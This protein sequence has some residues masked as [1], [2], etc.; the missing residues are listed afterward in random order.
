MTEDIDGVL[1][2]NTG[3]H[4]N[5]RRAR[6][7]D[8][9]ALAEFFTHVTPEDLRFRFLSGMKEVSHARLLEMTRADDRRTDNFL[10]FSTGETLV[11]VAML[12]SDDALRHG[13]VAISIRAD[14][15]H[16]G[17]SWEL[18]AH[19]SR[20][21]EKRGLETIESIESRDHREAIELEREMGFSVTA[22]PDDPKLVLVRRQL[23]DRQ[24]RS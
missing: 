2:T 24:S 14:H 9:A 12:A 21:A 11:A 18:L 16:M 10:A 17:I 7:E 8:E 1:I 23:G 6:P 20:Y 4:L 22:Y 19:I 5:V 3:V 13:E 15:K